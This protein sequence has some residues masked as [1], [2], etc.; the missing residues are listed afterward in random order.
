MSCVRGSDEVAVRN[1]LAVYSRSTPGTN[2]PRFTGELPR[3]SDSVRGTTTAMT[4]T[5]ASTESVGVAVASCRV[6]VG[7]GVGVAVPIV[8]VT[9]RAVSTFPATSTAR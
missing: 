8:T 9:F 4:S 7:V 3:V 2:G 5:W 1:V 6:A